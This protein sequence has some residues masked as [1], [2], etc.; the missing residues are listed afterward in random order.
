MDQT[1]SIFT[2]GLQSNIKEEVVRD[3]NDMTEVYEFLRHEKH[4]FE[5]AALDCYSLIQDEL[6]QTLL[7][8]VVKDKPHRDPDVPDKGDYL[9]NM[10][11]FQTWTRNITALP[12]NLIIT[13]HPFRVEDPDDDSV[14]YYPWIQGKDMPTKIAG[15]M[16]LVGHLKTQSDKKGQEHRVLVT[17]NT[18]KYYVKDSYGAFD[19]KIVDPTVPKMV[20][21]IEQRRKDSPKPTTAR[22]R[23]STRKRAAKKTTARK[24]TRS[25]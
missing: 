15:Y 6:L 12:I 22:K 16:K 1:D 14:L 4:D 24:R 2:M 25:K 17:G 11:R 13:T 23:A 3:W 21:R 20:E 8:D 5:W 18:D 7:D 9:R 10:K 19:G